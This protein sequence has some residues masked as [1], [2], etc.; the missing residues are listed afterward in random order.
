[1]DKAL[2]SG[3]DLICAQGTEAGGHTGDV[4]TM[5]LIPQ[6]VARCEGKKSPMDGSKCAKRR[7]ESDI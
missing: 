7:V 2:A 1:M 5:P 4:A 3:V 6:C